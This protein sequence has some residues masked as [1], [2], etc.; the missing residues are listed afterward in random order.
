MIFFSNETSANQ[1][2]KIKQ[3]QNNISILDIYGKRYFAKSGLKI[4]IGDFLK[5]DDKPAFIL[6]KKNKLCFSK[7]SSLKIKSIDDSTN[8]IIFKILKGKFLFFVNQNSK[9]KFYLDV[10][11]KIIQN[12]FG[13]IFVSKKTNK[14][15][16]IKTFKVD[17]NLYNT[18]SDKIR[19][20]SNSFYTFYNSDEF[21]KKAT[22][23]KESSF[24]KQCLLESSELNS[25]KKVFYKCSTLK[26]KIY[27]GYQESF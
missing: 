23:F 14:S 7:N 9:L 19:L 11:E 20:K 18:T 6:I 17:A 22:N 27:C 4:K 5:S 16:F 25:P 15:I 8:I 13:H 3:A 1:D 12:N 21:N 26:N 2:I 24:L 10:N